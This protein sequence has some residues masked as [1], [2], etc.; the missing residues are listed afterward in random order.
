MGLVTEYMQGLDRNG[1]EIHPNSSKLASARAV[2]SLTAKSSPGTIFRD[3]KFGLRGAYSEN[4]R[5]T[6]WR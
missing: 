1:G 6:T 4:S 2:R 3:P 5:V